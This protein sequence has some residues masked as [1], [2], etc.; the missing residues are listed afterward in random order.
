MRD[1]SYGDGAATLAGRIVEF[2]RL[3]RANHFRV[4]VQEAIDAC[5][6]AACVNITDQRQ[7]R[8][9]LRSLLCSNATDWAR[10]DQFFDRYWQR[11]NRRGMELR[12]SG[13]T[14]Q[15]D[16]SDSAASGSR[17]DP[18]PDAEETSRESALR[19]GASH[20][21]SATRSD[22]VWLNSTATPANWS[23]G[24]KTSPACCAGIRSKVEAIVSIRAARS[25]AACVTAVCR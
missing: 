20:R 11:S 24:L 10:F 21:E 13:N 18:L 19:V 14:G 15:V 22:F 4:D 9:G 16:P 6:G 25:G 8:W 12:A 23:S 17:R 2:V 1:I 3:M 7:L 5:K